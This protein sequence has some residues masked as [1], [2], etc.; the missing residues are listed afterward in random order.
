MLHWN[1]PSGPMAKTQLSPYREPGC[2]PWS[3]N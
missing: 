3:G 2:D 1:S